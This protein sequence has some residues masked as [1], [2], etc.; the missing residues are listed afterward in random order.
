MWNPPY[1]LLLSTAMT[2]LL[3]T[4]MWVLV[5]QSSVSEGLLA[6]TWRSSRPEAPVQRLAQPRC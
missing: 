5:F 3:S 4:A 6:A 1:P 2:L